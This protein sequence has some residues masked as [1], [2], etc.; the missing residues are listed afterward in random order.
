MGSQDG[1][2]TDVFVQ[3]WQK[4]KEKKKTVAGKKDWKLYNKQ[5]KGNIGLMLRTC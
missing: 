4:K 3:T 5:Q 1:V 2:V